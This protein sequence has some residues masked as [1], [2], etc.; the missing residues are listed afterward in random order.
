MKTRLTVIKEELE[1]VQ[2]EQGRKVGVEVDVQSVAPLH[3]L[4]EAGRLHQV[5]VHQGPDI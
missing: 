1:E 4:V 5:F 2:D 3:V